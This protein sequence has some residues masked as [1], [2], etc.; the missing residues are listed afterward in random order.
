MV[1]VKAVTTVYSRE[2]LG[3]Q[4][5]WS[6][7]IL[8]L[9]VTDTDFKRKGKLMSEM[10]IEIVTYACEEHKHKVFDIL[11]WH[12]IAKGLWYSKGLSLGFS[13]EDKKCFCGKP[14]SHIIRYKLP[15]K[16]KP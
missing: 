7:R 11:K 14:A 16:V 2:I 15:L 10:Q 5:N 12:L 1:H 3:V 8:G 4:M 13:F 6:Q 9:Y